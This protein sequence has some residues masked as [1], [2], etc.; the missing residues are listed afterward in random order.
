MALYA[1]LW[2]PTEFE[3][4]TGGFATGVAITV[5]RA[6]DNALATLYTDKS[7]TSTVSNPIQTDEFGNLSFWAE[8]DEYNLV[9]PG[10]E[11]LRVSIPKHP[12]EPGT[13]GE[14]AQVWDQNTPAATWTIPHTKGRIPVVQVY[15]AGEQVVGDIDATDTQ[16]VVTH[17][18]PV[19][20]KAILI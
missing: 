6:S 14:S 2:G 4:P 12:A 3:F 17:A 19:A 18:A 16:V 8:P 10:L 9:T 11:T 15:V 7:K 1:N 5:R 20:G 13:G